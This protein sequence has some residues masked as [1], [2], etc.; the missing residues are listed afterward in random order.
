MTVV[1]SDK[2]GNSTETIFD[3]TVKPK[4][5]TITTDLTDK[6]G[7]N[8]PWNLLGEA[9][10]TEDG[11]LRVPLSAVKTIPATGVV[12]TV[13]RN[14]T[15]SDK[16]PVKQIS[17][18]TDKHIVKVDNQMSATDKT[19]VIGETLTDITLTAED[20]QNGYLMR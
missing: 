17:Q 14:N 15:E 12:A 3:A 10:A 8:T 20:G 9:T 18:D 16:S 19:L 11:S 6:A 13:T 2:A 5:P 4:A 1:V 7:L